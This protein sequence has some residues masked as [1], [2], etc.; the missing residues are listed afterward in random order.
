[1]TTSLRR[2]LQARAPFLPYTRFWS[3]QSKVDIQTRPWRL[4]AT[5]LSA[6]GTLALLLAAVG[7]Y[8]VIAYSV[9]QRRQ[10]MGIR[11]ALGARAAQVM[12]LILVDGLR[13]AR[14]EER[15][16]GSEHRSG[17]ST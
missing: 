11:L 8:S 15:R 16:V 7:L 10:E 1:M 17:H 9:T 4:G 13:L 2:S 6:L 5:M 3:L 14:S 12:R